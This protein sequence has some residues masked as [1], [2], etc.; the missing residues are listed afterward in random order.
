VPHGLFSLVLHA[1][2]PFVRHPEHAE[3]LEEDWLFEAVTE[4][5]LPLLDALAR[6]RDSGARTRLTVSLSPTLCEMLRDPLLQFRYARHLDSLRALAE[7]EIARTAGGDPRFHATARLYAARLASA[8]R[9]WDETHAR[10]LVRAFG[11]LQEA[12]VVELVTCAATHG[13]LP[14]LSNEESRRAQVEVAASNYE[15]HF[16][17]RPRGIWLPESAYSAGL[18][19]H[20]AA[21]GLEYF[22]TDSHAVLYGEPR[23]R[24]GVH[25]PVRLWNG[26]AAFARDPESSEQVWSAQTGYPG[27]PFYREFY[28]DLGWDAPLEHLRPHLHADGRRRSLGLKFHRVTGRDVPLSDKQPYDPAAA[29]GRAREHAR[30]FVEERA[31]QAAR[32]GSLFGGRAPLVVAPFDAEL[33]GHWWYEGVEFLEHL[34]SR[35]DGRRAEIAPITPGDYLDSGARLQTQRLSQSSWGEEGYNK[36]WL[37]ER[38]AWMYPRQHAAEARMA[39]LAGR[40]AA[41]RDR[42]DELVSRALKQAARELL[43]A[44]SSDW[45]FQIYHGTTAGYAAARFDT[46]LERFH[47]LASA[48]EAGA[49]AR[50]HLE[51][52][53]GRD[54]LFPEID[55]RIFA[56]RAAG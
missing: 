24:Y 32:L 40:F 30:H 7:K 31:R 54:N 34:F 2:L 29:S 11:S 35:L 22:F 17:R 52:I 9:L 15:K 45:A 20:L 21:A 36:V 42:L 53:E 4:V 55:F 1:H 38:N 13:F 14:L 10:D 23:P 39:A 18:E 43:L 56:P 33:F 27:D 8:Q 49:V 16:G 6:L 12:G 41:R 44:Q 19:A 26:V 47:A 46:H 25:A 50:D 5:Y 51:E 28:R 37:N 48:A 3:F